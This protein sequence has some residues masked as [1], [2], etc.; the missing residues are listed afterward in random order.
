MSTQVAEVFDAIVI[1]SGQGGNPL[2]GALVGA[3]KKTAL[4]ERQDVGGTCINRGCTPTKTMVAS[5]RAAYL[6]RRGADY[7]VHV[8]PVTVDMNRVRERKRAIVQSWREGGEKRLEKAHVELVR[9]EASFTG[10][11]QI[12]VALHGGGE[13]QLSAAQFF[14]NTG[15][16]SGTPAIEG[17]K[18]VP[19]LDNE[20]IMEL[21]YVPEHL[22]ILGGGY[23]GV[24]FSQMFRRFGSKVT[25]IQAGPQLL[26]E[27]DQEVAEE[28]VKILRQDGIEILLNAHTEKVERAYGIVRLT[29]TIDGHAQ[30]IEGT[31]LLVA[32]GRAPN[33]DTLNPAA[34]GIEID[35]HGFIRSNDRLETSA[36]GVYVLGDVKGGPQFTHISYDDYRIL[37]TNLLDGGDRTVRDRPVP[38]AVFMDP[39]LGRVG[40]TER[41]AKKS[42]R[43]IRVAR[44]PMT[45]VARALEVDETR[46]LMKVI[47]DAETE[48]IL[49]ATVLG[50]EG[51][52]VMA[53]LQ[54][55]IM[56]NMKYTV[57]R[58]GV[59][60]H[61][62]L[63]ESLNNLFFHF[64]DGK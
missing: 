4:I 43:K 50:I 47:V 41:D 52:E 48:Q 54:M 40:M 19:Y 57:L 22:V 30:T 8:G 49:G 33:T 39:Q 36:P 61:P 64:D 2:A 13:R 45:S 28:V 6:A 14:I 35:Q 18:T 58:D 63:A 24:E 38:Y 31:D 11:K 7:G 46:G 51:G 56:G 29:V 12:R 17:L 60:A 55:A 62:T 1:G 25:V 20:S 3:G 23:I 10:P 37:K 5:A 32:T 21:D 15:T 26:R 34:A 53:V 59:F 27:E 9:G 42:A 16:H 44:M